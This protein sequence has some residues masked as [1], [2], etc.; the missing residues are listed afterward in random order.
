MKPLK[1][2]SFEVYQDGKNLI[3]VADV[4]LP[5]IEYLSDTVKGAGIAGEIDMPTL[6]Q[7]GSMELTMNFRTIITDLN[8]IAAPGT[9]NIELWA[10]QQAYD[11]GTGEDVVQRVIIAVRGVVKKATL[12]KF[13]TGESTD[14]SV[15]MEVLRMRIEIDG[16]ETVLIDKMNKVARFK[17]NDFLQAV[18]QAVGM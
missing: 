14:T 9:K 18:R 17:G 7:Y 6:G 1:I 10:A 11:E 5:D 4:T 3:G 12:G 16:R 13:S 2:A 8:T 15:A